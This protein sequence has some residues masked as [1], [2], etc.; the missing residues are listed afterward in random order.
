MF[1]H[2]LLIEFALN[3]FFF[4][5]FGIELKLT[6]VQLYPKFD[7]SSILCEN[8]LSKKRIKLEEAS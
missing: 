1:I 5:A 7:Y 4:K 6:C 3:L 2:I 8:G